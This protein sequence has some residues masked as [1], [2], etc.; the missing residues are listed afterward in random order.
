MKKTCNNC[1][2]LSE[3]S[4]SYKCKLGYKIKVNHIEYTIVSA[5]PLENCPKPK[6]THEFINLLNK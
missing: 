1:K 3:Y 4:V 2:A 5:T 6:T